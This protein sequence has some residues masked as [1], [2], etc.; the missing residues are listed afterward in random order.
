MPSSTV[1]QCDRRNG[2]SLGSMDDVRSPRWITSSKGAEIL[3]CTIQH[4]RLLI[5]KGTLSATKHGRDWVLDEQD[6]ARLRTTRYDRQ[7][8]RPPK[9]H[10]PI[11]SLFYEA[12]YQPIVN[13]ASVPKRSPFRYPGGKTWLIPYARLWLRSLPAKPKLLVEPFAG[14][15]SIGLTAGF[16]SLTDYVLMVELDPDVAS[17]WRVAL[18]GTANELCER[19]AAFTCDPEN[20][21]AALSSVPRS[22]LDRA[23]QTIVRNRVSRG[24]ILAPG[25]GL[26]KKGEAGKGISSRW[27]PHT[28][29]KRIRDLS[30]QAANI[31]FE[32]ADGFK[33][34]ENHLTNP[35]VA[36]FIDPPYPKAG[37]RLYRF[38]EV[39]HKALFALLAEAEGPVLVTYDH[40]Q[41]VQGLA[42][43]FGF[44]H[45]MVPMKSTH[46]EMK[47]E[48]LIS[49]DLSW[50]PSRKAG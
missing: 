28:I 41:E 2:Y 48:L 39:D 14:G 22:D 6:V 47:F 49:K 11:H 23:F 5:R 18:N 21:R 33:A 15:G 31:T 50:V 36:M 29:I 16:E 38:H 44:D 10:E 13:V 24:G 34:I 25:S 1:W 30:G 32:E 17:V 46:H 37:R 35:Q 42:V 26:V 45:E 8:T 12:E 4:L 27:Y 7:A 19:I 43:E 9:L 20:V 3:G 40:S